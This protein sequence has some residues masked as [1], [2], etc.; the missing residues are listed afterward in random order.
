LP[1][2]VTQLDPELRKFT[3]LVDGAVS[4]CFVTVM[5]DGE[6]KLMIQEDIKM[7]PDLI[8]AVEDALDELKCQ[9]RDKWHG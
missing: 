3:E 4:C 6:P 7:L 8:C 9:Y 5:S 1:D 2:K